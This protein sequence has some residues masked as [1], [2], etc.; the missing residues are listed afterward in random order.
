MFKNFAKV[1]TPTTNNE[2]LSLSK[3]KRVEL[4]KLELKKK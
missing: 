4:I 2:W 3:E 1:K